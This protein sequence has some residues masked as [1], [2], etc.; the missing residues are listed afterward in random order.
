MEA[1]ALHLFIFLFPIKKTN[2]GW[3]EQ[4]S[5]SISILYK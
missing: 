3:L 2:D 1:V 4:L 5:R